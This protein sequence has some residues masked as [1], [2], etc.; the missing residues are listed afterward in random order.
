MF[1]NYNI[2]WSLLIKRI[3]DPERR[4][5]VALKWIYALLKPIIDAH[6]DFL[7]FRAQTMIDLRWNGQT[8]YLEYGLNF[9]FN[10]DLPAYTGS[11]PTG[12]YIIQP[13]DTLNESIW[14][15]ETD[16]VTAE[17]W[18]DE[19]DYVADPTL[20]EVIWYENADF[21]GVIDFIVRVPIALGDVTTNLVLASEIVAFV[22]KYKYSGVN[23]TIENY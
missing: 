11:T 4:D 5:A 15:D 9:T 20:T 1:N 14:Y 2:N 19:A 22:N 3:V 16:G 7:A 6:S 12:I 8:I 21:D 23:F 17:V 18:Y 10:N 13:T